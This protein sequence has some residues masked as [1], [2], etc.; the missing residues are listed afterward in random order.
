VLRLKCPGADYN[1]WWWKGTIAVGAEPL[2]HKQI[3]DFKYYLLVTY[4]SL[5]EATQDESVA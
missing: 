3:S 2:P 5:Y 4:T 1:A